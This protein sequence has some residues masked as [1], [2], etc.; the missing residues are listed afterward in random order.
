M[1]NNQFHYPNVFLSCT[2]GKD[3]FS[4]DSVDSE[5][6]RKQLRMFSKQSTAVHCVLSPLLGGMAQHA[7]K[8]VLT[9]G[10]CSVDR[11]ITG[12]HQF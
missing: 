1:V 7:Q 5:L 10:P 2:R 8:E 11:T 3:S 12:D 9:Q 4:S 6:P